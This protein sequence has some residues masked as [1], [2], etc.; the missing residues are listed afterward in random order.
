MEGDAG[1]SR[2][3]P[4]DEQ[5]THVDPLTDP[6]DPSTRPP[7]QDGPGTVA[8][9]VA[10]RPERLGRGWGASMVVVLVLLAAGAAAGGYF[11]LRAHAASAAMAHDEVVA[12]ATARDCVTATQAP[13]FAVMSASQAKM[14][15]CATGDFGTQAAVYSGLLADAYQTANVKVQVTDMRAAPERHNDDGSIDVLVAFR[16]K[17]SNMQ[18]AD[19]EQG[20]RLRVQMAPV[21]GT[22]KVAKLEQVTS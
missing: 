1:A 9:Q 14:I 2:L 17:V 5:D 10:R 12:V 22:F 13:D 7:A 18:A 6:D 15:E 16:V 19:Q 4:T 21:D 3:N 8:E 11:A 20:Y